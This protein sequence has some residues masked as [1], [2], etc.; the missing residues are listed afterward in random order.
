[1]KKNK[2]KFQ[3]QRMGVTHVSPTVLTKQF[4]LF[5]FIFIFVSIGHSNHLRY[6]SNPFLV[7]LDLNDIIIIHVFTSSSNFQMATKD[8]VTWLSQSCIYSMRKWAQQRMQ[9][10]NSVLLELAF[11]WEVQTI[12]KYVNNFVISKLGRDECTEEKK[13]YQQKELENQRRKLC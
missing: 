1:M 4:S 5:H 2:S 7:C 6:N 12:G 11:Y 3:K 8:S 9:G 13:V 10:P